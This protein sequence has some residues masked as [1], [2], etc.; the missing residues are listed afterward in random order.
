MH[1]GPYL[2]FGSHNIIEMSV[3]P[4]NLQ[5]QYVHN[6]KIPADCMS[7]H[8]KKKKK[9]NEVLCS[10]HIVKRQTGRDRYSELPR[11]VG[12]GELLNLPKSNHPSIKNKSIR[13]QKIPKKKK[14]TTDTQL[15]KTKIV[16]MRTKPRG[17]RKDP[18]SRWGQ[19]AAQEQ[20]R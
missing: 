16:R 15:R 7:V 10:K 8:I 11:A 1:D 2:L 14:S 4:V 17:R 5:N 3:L 12:Q 20:V 9:Q 6:K 13:K 19:R 18:V